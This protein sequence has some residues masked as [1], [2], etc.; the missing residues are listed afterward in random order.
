MVT[1]FFKPGVAIGANNP[2]FVDM[3]AA[4]GA[5]VRFFQAAQ[6]RFFFQCFL[7]FFF[8]R[9]AGAQDKINHDPGQK[10][11]AYN[12]YRENTHKCILTACLD[13]APRPEDETDP[14]RD[15]KSAAP[16]GKNQD[17]AADSRRI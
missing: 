10:Q 12:E 13:I 16:S 3:S 14:E 2:V 6:Q 8:Q 9:G 11:Y 15:K 17:C 4:S 1:G 5:F 7:V